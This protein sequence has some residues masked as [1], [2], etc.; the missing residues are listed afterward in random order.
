MAAVSEYSFPDPHAP[1]SVL[2][3]A[4]SLPL[5]F[6][7]YSHVGSNG[8]EGFDATGAIKHYHNSWASIISPDGR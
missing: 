2:C 4:L 3:V 6:A 8:V 1:R 5:L 7:L